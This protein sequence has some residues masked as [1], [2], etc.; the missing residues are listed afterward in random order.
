MSDNGR[1]TTRWWWVR[2]APAIDPEG[3]LYGQRDVDC[4]VS[5]R[6]AFDRLAGMLPRD[7]VWVATPLRRTT[8]TAAAI[9]AAGLAAPEPVI[10]PR[11]MEQHFGEWQG[12]KRSEIV[13]H[14]LWIAAPD[15]TPPGGENF[16]DMMARVRAAIGELTDAHR[17][18]D[19]VAVAH[20]GTIR[21][22]LGVALELPPDRALAFATDNLA[23]TVIER[24]ALTD[25]VN[26]WRVVAVNRLPR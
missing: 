3:R 5:E 9:R 1:T 18:R 19:I 16:I 22:A 14:H 7:A 8:K 17:G 20:G 15:A 10:E 4:D 12:V 21:C 13:R 23:V 11:F 26:D 25:R 6:A 24:F 2:H